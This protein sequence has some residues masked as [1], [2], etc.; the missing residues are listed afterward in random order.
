[1]DTCLKDR[2]CNLFSKTSLL[3]YCISLAQTL[4]QTGCL[5]SQAAR[6]TDRHRHTLNTLQFQSYPTQL[7]NCLELRYNSWQLLLL[8]VLVTLCL[9]RHRRSSIRNVYQGSRIWRVE[10]RARLGLTLLGWC[11]LTPS[12]V[13][14]GPRLGLM[15]CWLTGPGGRCWARAVFC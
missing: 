1:M 12:F 7:I 15:T 6:Q 4:L 3:S 2:I 14:G 9:R 13:R 11:W 5:D 10:V 8:S